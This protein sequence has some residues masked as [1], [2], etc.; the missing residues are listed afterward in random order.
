MSGCG[1]TMSSLKGWIQLAR[2][3]RELPPVARP[4]VAGCCG[5][6]QLAASWILPPSTGLGA[7][8]ITTYPC[9]CRRTEHTSHR[10]GSWSSSESF[11]CPRAVSL[12]SVWK[13]ERKSRLTFERGMEPDPGERSFNIS[14][15]QVRTTS[16][17]AIAFLPCTGPVHGRWRSAQRSFTMDWERLYGTTAP[18][19]YPNNF[20]CEMASCTMWQTSPSERPARKGKFLAASTCAHRYRP[21]GRTMLASSRLP[22]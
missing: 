20:F 2:S 13:L 6:V 7:S 17:V 12:S 22:K 9:P 18:F 1:M 19:R 21:P 15:K 14:C 16:H 4:P 5:G 11:A 8:G 10:R 3:R